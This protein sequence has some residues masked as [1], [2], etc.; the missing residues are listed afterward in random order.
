MTQLVQFGA[1]ILH[2]PDIL[3]LDEPFSGLDPVNSRRMKEI[4]LEEKRRGAAIIFSTHQ[5]M[6]VEELSDRVLMVDD[7]LVALEG[8]P[9]ELRRRYRGDT[10][11]VESPDPPPDT[12]S[13]GVIIDHSAETTTMRLAPMEL[14]LRTFCGSYSTR[15]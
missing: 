9:N 8:A 1:T 13:G 2:R 4:V 15:E 6:D 7:G 12:I 11:R 10:I 14:R 5:M 3:V